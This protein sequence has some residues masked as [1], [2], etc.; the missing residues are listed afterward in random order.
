M[1][2]KWVLIIAAVLG[3]MA[4]FL[5]NV[6]IQQRDTAPDVRY[7]QV[8]VAAKD[9]AK[10]TTIDYN[11]LAFKPIPVNFVEPGALSLRESAV[12]KAAMVT[13]MAGEQI[14]NSKLA[15]PGT[16]LTLAVKTPPGKRATTITLE[17]ASAVGGMVRPG[18][19]VDILGVFSTPA[20][21]LTLFQNVIVLAVGSQ[22]VPGEMQDR[23]AAAQASSA[24]SSASVTLAL[25][26]QQVQV[27]TVAMQHG[28]IRMTLRPH[29]ETEQALPEIDLSNLSAAFDFNSLLQLYIAR[30]QLPVAKAGPEVEII[31]GLNKEITTV[32]TAKKGK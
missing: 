5:T 12:G 10:G 30:P 1:Q 15:A 25:S 9:I 16:G 13:I 24:R 28:K 31:R 26:P 22:M 6:Y 23:R 4:V 21:T 32:P 29:M 7:K 20:I 3:L 11:M 2:R 17:S 14:L 19:H 18:D 27:L 8:L